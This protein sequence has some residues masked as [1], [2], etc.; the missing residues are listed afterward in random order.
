MWPK[1]TSLNAVHVSQ[2]GWTL[3][4][5]LF[6]CEARG[7]ASASYSLST[8]S[9]AMP[10]PQRWGGCM[11]TP[12]TSI[13][14]LSQNKTGQFASEFTQEPRFLIHQNVHLISTY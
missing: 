11:H 4:T 7:L 13:T 3:M 14:I 10:A 6:P 2:K 5:Y 1:T 12:I 9:R 8:C